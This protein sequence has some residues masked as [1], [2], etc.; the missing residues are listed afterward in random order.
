MAIKAEEM[1]VFNSNKYHQQQQ[2]N[3]EMNS[4]DLG[5]A[6]VQTLNGGNRTIEWNV[7]VFTQQWALTY[8][9]VW[10]LANE[11]N[12]CNLETIMENNFWRVHGIWPTKV[13]TMGPNYCEYVEFDVKIANRLGKHYLERIWTHIDAKNKSENLWKDEW[14]KHGS[15]SLEIEDLSNEY[16]YLYQGMKWWEQ[17]QLYRILNDSGIVPGKEYTLGN[18]TML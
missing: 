2:K 13:G 5:T 9:H 12:K 4:R 7:I 10:R 17:F 3:F 6:K 16:K 18:I 11:T 15:C 8:C 14:I 1:F